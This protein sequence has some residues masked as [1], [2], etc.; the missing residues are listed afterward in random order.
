VVRE[1][2]ERVRRARETVDAARDAAGDR[3]SAHR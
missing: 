3:R 2:V 1:A